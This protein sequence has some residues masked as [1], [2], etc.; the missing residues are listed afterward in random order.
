M[1]FARHLA[2]VL[3]VV[4]VIVAAGVALAY[5]T[6]GGSAAGGHEITR[7]L[8]AAHGKAPPG[9][10]RVILVR[11]PA[12]LNFSRTKDLI[13]TVIIE[14]ALMAVVITLDLIRRRTR[15]TRRQ[16]R[17]QGQPETP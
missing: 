12:A 7:G 8:E 9:P 13:R 4:A 14:A 15:R 16:Q 1:K 17:H 2:A 3:L 5:G 6:W 11:P 10:G